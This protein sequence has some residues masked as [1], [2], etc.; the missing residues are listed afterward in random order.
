MLSVLIP[1]YNYSC[2]VLVEELHKQLTA[3]AIAF[4]IKCLDDASEFF[5]SENKTVSNLTYTTYEISNINQG[6]IATRQ[7]LANAAMYDWLLFIDA[8]VLLKSNRFIINYLKVLTETVDAVYG[9]FDYKD[10]KPG[11]NRTLRWKYGKTKEKAAAIKRNA[12]PYKIVIS[13]NFL[14]KKAVFLNLN[15]K[16]DSKGYGYDNYFGALLKAQNNK[17]L[18]IDN[19]VF[20][21]GIEDNNIYLKKTKQA[22]ETLHHLHKTSKINVSENSLLELFKT[23]KSYKLHIILSVFYKWF[24]KVTE[25]QLTGKNPSITLLQLYKLGYICYLDRNA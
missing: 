8:D 13:A 3:S 7:Q 4:E 15:T 10:E 6:R 20:H 9:G 2:K 23:L 11:N 5:T 21:L 1:V 16:V 22:V 19:E 14:I 17:V 24:H 12:S 18:H 25:K